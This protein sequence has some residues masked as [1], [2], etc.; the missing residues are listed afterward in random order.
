MPEIVGNLHLH[1]VASDG[2]GTHDEVAAAAARAG[3][4][5][6][7]YTDHNVETEGVAGWFHDPTTGRKILRLMGQEVNDQNLEPE[8]NHLL[9]YFTSADFNG[10]AAD[11]QKLI[12]TIIRRQGLCF[13]AHPLERPGYGRAAEVYPWIS[14]NVSGFTG[15]ELWNAMTDIKWR[16]RQLW[17]WGILGAYLPHWVLSGPLPEMLAKWDELLAG[18]QKVVAIGSSDAHAMSFSLGP[19][20]RTV[21]PYEHLFQTINTHVLLYDPLAA[22]FNQAQAQIYEALSR[23][24]CFVSY[25]FIGSPRGFVFTGTSGSET[26]TMGETLML[27]KEAL[28]RIT[29]PYPAYLRLLKDGQVIIQTE[30]GHLT[31]LTTEPGIYRVEAYRHFWGQK[32]G[33]VFTNPIYVK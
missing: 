32:R 28:L 19:L 20:R 11:P 24:N 33:W 9:C 6:I 25:D 4:D 15:I 23:G 10:V 2:T 7:I 18:G 14:W 21:Y 3:L 30:S 17:P 26:V 8:L 29:S 16:L 12:D 27:Q 13:L 5:F 31:W 1:T 22:D